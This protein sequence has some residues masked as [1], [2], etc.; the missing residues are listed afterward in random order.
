MLLLQLAI[1]LIVLG[2]LMGLWV[3]MQSVIRR[4]TPDAGPEDDML[5]GR[6]GCGGCIRKGR[7][8]NDH[9]DGVNH[10]PRDP[11]SKCLG[12]G[13]SPRTHVP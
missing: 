10:P 13:Y 5:I 1:T 8:E 6:W 3:F 12:S 11:G 4:H 7:C 9:R 2:L